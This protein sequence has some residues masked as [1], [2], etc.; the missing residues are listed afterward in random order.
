LKLTGSKLKLTNRISQHI[1]PKQLLTLLYE[2]VGKVIPTRGSAQMRSGF[3]YVHSVE[4]K[5]TCLKI[6]KS[7]TG[8]DLRYSCRH[9]SCRFTFPIF[10]HSWRFSVF[11]SLQSITP[12]IY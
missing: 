3:E 5:S 6:S 8:C 4:K 1:P 7:R 12:R 11:H 2:P 9:N 10:A